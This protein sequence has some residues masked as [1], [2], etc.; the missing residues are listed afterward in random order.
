MSVTIVCAILLNLLFVIVIQADQN[1]VNFQYKNTVQLKCTLIGEDVHFYRIVKDKEDS[2]NET[3]TML[4]NTD[5]IHIDEAEKTITLK[6]LRRDD[7]EAEYICKDGNSI[8]QTFTKKIMPF[9]ARPEKASITITEGGYAEM[10]CRVLYGNEHD[11]PVTW[12]WKR[13][14][15]EL[16]SN[17]RLTIDSTQ[18]ETKLNIT[19]LTMEDRGDYECHLN[20]NI[21]EHQ[22]KV[23]LRVKDAL[24]VLWPFLAII[25]EVVILSAII[26]IYEKKCTKKH[27]EE[28]I[29]QTQNLMGAD[30]SQ[31][32][33]LKK[34]TA[35]A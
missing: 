18:N 28:D 10:Y 13:N 27:R 32:S 31:G 24:A 22:E 9:V 34:R 3:H 11:T 30:A 5:K 8:K 7:I 29:D 21:G 20:N 33:D 19:K 17:D 6:D 15:T 2:A 1:V 14:G 12:V 16:V 23:T 25:A 35:K 4:N 26:L